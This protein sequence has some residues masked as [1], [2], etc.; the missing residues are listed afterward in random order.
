MNAAT[1]IT[2]STTITAYGLVAL[3]TIDF[4][5]CPPLATTMPPTTS[6]P[7]PSLLAR[8]SLC[9]QYQL[10]LSCYYTVA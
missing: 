5:F 10:N 8:P 6:P 9:C 7:P 4:T 1:P 3:V 2:L